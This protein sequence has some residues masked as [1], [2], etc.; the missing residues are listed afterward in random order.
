MSKLSRK[1][2]RE[3]IFNLL[4]ET[5]F[6]PG[7]DREAI[8]QRS[9]ENR[10]FIDDSFIR[11]GYFGVYEHL[12]EIDDLI[13]RHT[14]NNWK[15]SRMNAVSRSVLRLAVYEMKYISS[16]PYTVSLNEAVELTKKFD[17]EKARPFVNGILN[18]IKDELA[19]ALA[20]TEAS[21]DK[22]L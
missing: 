9:G 1:E 4:F 3:E 21:H 10:N 16:I 7:E 22:E 15:T 11:D 17:E 6:H 14:K 20:N 19:E 13:S 8:Y 2:E 12:E 18:S 5:E